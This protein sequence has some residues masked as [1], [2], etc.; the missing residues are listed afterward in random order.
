MHK[1]NCKTLLTFFLQSLTP[2]SF[3]FQL[4]DDD[5][6]IRTV[7]AWEQEERKSSRLEEVIFPGFMGRG[8]AILL[9][10]HLYLPK[11]NEQCEGK[12]KF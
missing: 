1:F 4:E 6:S 3:N 2:V 10:F 8:E 12:A 7:G 9:T 5:S 11:T